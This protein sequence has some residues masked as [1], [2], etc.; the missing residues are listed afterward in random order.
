MHIVKEPDDT[1][2]DDSPPDQVVAWAL[3]RFAGRELVVTTSFGMEGC[4]LIDMV[5]AHRRPVR[6]VYLDTMFLFPETYALRDRM[7]ERY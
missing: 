7:V 3:E 6:V 2:G 1:I 5:A 4:A